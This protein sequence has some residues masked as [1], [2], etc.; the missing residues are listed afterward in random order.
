MVARAAATVGGATAAVRAAVATVAAT[1]AA[2]L[3]AVAWVCRKRFHHQG[4]IDPWGSC[5]RCTH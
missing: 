5:R 1:V 2:E 4:S 3:A